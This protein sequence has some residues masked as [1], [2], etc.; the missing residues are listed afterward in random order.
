MDQGLGES[1]VLIYIIKKVYIEILI[2][3]LLLYMCYGA[4]G[5][6]LEKKSRMS[7]NHELLVALYQS[8]GI[9]SPPPY[10][11]EWHNCCG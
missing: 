8:Q 11:D 5:Y 3:D 6:A 2:Q 7:E 4:F 9:G 1:N 10:L